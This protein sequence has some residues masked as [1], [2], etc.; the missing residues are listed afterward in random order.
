MLVRRLV[1]LALCALLTACALTRTPVPPATSTLAA[2]SG[3]LS[4]RAQASET[5]STP[6]TFNAQFDLQGSPQGG[7]LQLFGP[8]GTTLAEVSWEA[9]FARLRI[10]GESREYADLDALMTDLLGINLPTQ[11]LFAWLKGDALAPPGWQVNLS[12]HA[13]GRISALKLSV[14]RAQFTL[15]FQ[16]QRL[17]GAP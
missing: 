3:R 11:A 7:A 12:E 1:L 17:G 6:S 2:W 4:M 9:G 10:R 14:P 15:L 16:A 5:A 13:H 8:L